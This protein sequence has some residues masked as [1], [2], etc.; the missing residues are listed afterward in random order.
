MAKHRTIVGTA[1]AGTTS[2]VVALLSTSAPAHAA[3]VSTWDRVAECESG[4]NWSISTGNGYYG[5]LQFS[6][7]TWAA[8]GGRHFAVR[9]D[10]A[11][12]EQQITVAERVLAAQGPGAWPVC[13]VR[14]GL[15]RGGQR[16]A[17]PVRR[18][19]TQPG[20]ASVAAQ[21]VSYA[22]GALGK[23]YVHGATGPGAYD[24][25]GLTMAAWRAAGVSIPRT[26]QAQWSGLTRVAPSQVQP[27]DIVVYAG[28]GH[29]ALYVGGGQIIE[30]P[31]PG[32]SVQ[33]A[34]WRSG[35]YADHF[36]G[37]VRP[38]GASVV[39]Q[40]EPKREEAAPAKPKP[41]RGTGP[42]VAAV[43]ATG[44]YRVKAGDTLSS[45]AHA[46]GFADWRRLYEANT[47]HVYDPDLIFPGQVLRIPDNNGEAA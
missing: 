34:P 38:A 20:K 19:A 15:A 35:W 28:A 6:S 11:T 46:H 22:R 37:V 23:P 36:V 29:V 41:R 40:A 14:A 10:L 18:A 4:G 24:C 5:G 30:S 31:R 3:S 8:Y 27:G 39:V 13:G 44:R 45:V 26:S 9:A 47:D 12:R 17:Q 2:T 42:G 25:S 7:S 33:T 16:A 43:M 21:A 32:R 1:L